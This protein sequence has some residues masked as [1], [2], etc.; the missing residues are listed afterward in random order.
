MDYFRASMEPVHQCLQDSGLPKTAI[1]EVVLVGGSTR[2]PKVQSMISEFFGG[3]ELCK[4]I[5]P[6]EAVAFGAAVQ[7]AIVTG[8]GSAE[9]QN[10]LLLDVT[11]L[12]LGLETVGG[13]MQ[14]LIERN[15]TIPSTKAMD[16]STTADYQ[17]S[18]DISVYEGERA[19]VAD[20]NFLGTFTLNGIPKSLRGVPKVCVTFG[21]DSNGILEVCA[22]DVRQNNKSKIQITNDKGRLTPADIE[23]MLEEAEKHKDEDDLALGERIARDHLREHMDKVRTE[24]DSTS[25]AKLLDK[26]RFFIDRKWHEI[27]HWLMVMDWRAT[28]EECESRQA[29]LDIAWQA[30]LFK[31]SGEKIHYPWEKTMAMPENEALASEG[32]FYIESGV[33]LRQF[34]DEPC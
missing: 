5:N 32:G 17:Q 6:D 28:K 29:G 12:S 34:F 9:V 3:K 19:K 1:A 4:S 10:M 30:M 18:V 26:D 23:R 14:K 13:M 25:E 33:D 20:N 16:F 22:E 31:A 11:P 15:T 8:G 21:L 27:S 2:I 7:A 24:I